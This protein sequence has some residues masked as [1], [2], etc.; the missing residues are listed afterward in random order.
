ME[1]EKV[2]IKSNSP[3]GYVYKFREEI[4][5]GDMKHF[6]PPVEK[7]ETKLDKSSLPKDEIKEK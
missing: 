4:Q 3:L 5:P 6:D 7:K 2:K 1:R